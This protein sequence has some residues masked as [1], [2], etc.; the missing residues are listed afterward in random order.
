MK[1]TGKILGITSGIIGIFLS[2]ALLILGLVSFSKHYDFLSM[3]MVIGAILMILLSIIGLVMS[4]ISHK[5]T[6][7]SSVILIL[8]GLIGFVFSY[9]F[10]I[11]SVL[12]II[13]AIV[14]LASKRR[15]EVDA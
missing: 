13:S 14:N 3:S 10:I 8:V 6:K 11:S 12:F 15:A 4:L 2:T 7:T 9:F 5:Y 1:K